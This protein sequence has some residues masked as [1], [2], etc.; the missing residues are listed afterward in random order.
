VSA[1]TELALHA[2]MLVRLEDA[3]ALTRTGLDLSSRPNMTYEQY[4][5]IGTLLG[6]ASAAIRWAVGDWLAFGEDRFGELAAQAAETL[7]ISP[8]GRMELVRVARAIPHHRRRLSLSWTHHR[9]V[10]RRSITPRQREELLDRAEAEGWNAREIEAEARGLC[11]KLSLP[12]KD[13]GDADDC[14]AVLV[15]LVATVRERL[16]ACG[17]DRKAVLEVSADAAV[18]RP[19]PGQELRI[20]RGTA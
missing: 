14:E 11:A 2:D 16:R 10:A 7:N 4:E 13:R 3:G 6:R 20:G 15:E 8:E 18:L 1:S 5:A 9:A 17:Y 19:F 12:G